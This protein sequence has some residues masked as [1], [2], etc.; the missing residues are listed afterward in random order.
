MSNNKVTKKIQ[1]NELSDDKKGP[2]KIRIL[3]TLFGLGGGVKLTPLG[4]KKIFSFKWLMGRLCDL[5]TFDS[6][7]RGSF[8]PNLRVI[9]NF[10]QFLQMS[11]VKMR[12][13]KTAKNRLF[14]F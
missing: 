6:R 10:F 11:K 8:W 13:Q 2:Q 12:P 1:R 4:R 3:L 9:S 5:M 7:L 14:K